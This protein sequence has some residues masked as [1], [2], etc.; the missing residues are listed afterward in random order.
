MKYSTKDISKFQGLLSDAKQWR[1]PLEDNWRFMYEMYT[2]NSATQTPMPEYG[3]HIN[4][5]K[6]FELT[7]T[8]VSYFMQALMFRDRFF[9]ASPMAIGS[10]Q[11][12]SLA[13]ELLA[14]YIA[15]SNFSQVLSEVLRQLI[16]TGNTGMT[17]SVR[18]KKLMFEC[19][20]MFRTYLLPGHSNEF[21]N[22]IYEYRLSEAELYEFYQE[23]PEIKTKFEEFSLETGYAIT[24][25]AN[26][27]NDINREATP[28]MEFYQVYCH[29]Y[30]CY[31]TGTY[32]TCWYSKTSVLYDRKVK[33]EVIPLVIPAITLPSSPY[34]FSPLESSIGL[35][36][37]LTSIK[38]HRAIAAKVSSY[39]MFVTDDGMVPDDMV[40]EPNKVFRTSKP[41]A[42]LPLQMPAQGYQVNVSEEEILKGNI[43]SNVGL[44][45]GVS[46]NAA[47]TGDRVTATEI[48]GLQKAS[49]TRL[50]LLF[51]TLEA[52]LFSPIINYANCVLANTPG[53]ETIRVYNIDTDSYDIYSM[54]FTKLKEY[55]IILDVS[56]VKERMEAVQKLLDFVAA[57]GNIPTAQ[58]TINFPNLVTDIVALYGFPDPERYIKKPEP[59]PMEQNTESGG[60]YQESL[61]S[62]EG[63]APEDNRML[64]SLQQQMQSDPS[65]AAM[66]AGEDPNDP[67][68]FIDQEDSLL[69]QQVMQQQE[70]N[71]QP[72]EGSY[73]A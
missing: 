41:D 7:E 52:R 34:G 63:I 55:K 66:V 40:F 30:W 5:G 18:N 59:A 20:D 60:V 57:V 56:K 58:E 48:D 26:Q 51:T 49:G 11:Y 14:D 37:E 50:N 64:A 70:A 10:Q 42:L 25:T 72:G 6:V 39:Y 4:T 67:Q 73:V 54:A 68:T 65:T 71:I 35:I 12:S 3:V 9:D 47:R 33:Q 2:N 13:V 62:P 44:G 17:V 15:Q 8:F 1:Q 43:Y 24:E 29:Y 46:A 61:Q 69:R 16:L 23:S 28:Q 45:N 27:G 22:F 53:K 21:P 31:K 38:S 32:R 36:S 19:L